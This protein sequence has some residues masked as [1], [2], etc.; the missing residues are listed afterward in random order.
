MK[1]SI[2]LLCILLSTCIGHAADSLPEGLPSL[3]DTSSYPQGFNRALQAVQAAPVQ[4]VDVED[5]TIAY[6]TLGE[7]E[8][9]FCITGNGD[10]M[11]LWSPIF[12]Y[13]LSLTHKV[14]I[15]DNRGAGLTTEGTAPFT[16]EQF[17]KDTAG[18]IRAM[19]YEK[20]DLLGFSMGSRIAAQLTIDQPALIKKVVLY[21]CAPGGKVEIKRS[22]ATQKIFSDT[23]GT[24]QQKAERMFSVLI[25]AD[26]RAAHPDTS[27]YFPKVTE[28]I[29]PEVRAKQMSA[30]ANW[31]G[32]Y[33]Q[34]KT[35]QTPTLIMAGTADE[36]V[37]PGNALL[38]V[39][40]IPASWLVRFRDGGHGMMFQFPSQLARAVDTF[41]ATS[42]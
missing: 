6:K 22:A 13:R 21:G 32:I 25:P 15:F 9:L 1:K 18:F 42:N 30:V 24:E 23:S 7:G 20:T 33:D 8:P 3:P 38:L 16:I 17:A 31:P 26:W 4:H 11:D 34:L 10:T 36:V 37:P 41:L 39:E 19:G 29:T 27:R 14:Y 12:I 35:I 40:Q 28:T 5:I 2:P